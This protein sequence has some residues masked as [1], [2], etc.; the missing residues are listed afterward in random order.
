MLRQLLAIALALQLNLPQQFEALRR[1]D[2]WI[3]RTTH[4]PISVLRDDVPDLSAVFDHLAQRI[5]RRRHDNSRTEPS[6]FT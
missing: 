1:W 5:D 3:R 2:G 4:G 6:W